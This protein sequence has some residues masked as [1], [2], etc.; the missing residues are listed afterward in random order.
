MSSRFILKR[1]N[2]SSPSV[3]DLAVPEKKRKLKRKVNPDLK[4]PRP[5]VDIRTESVVS[6]PNRRVSVSKRGRLLGGQEVEP[7]EIKSKEARRSKTYCDPSTEEAKQLRHTLAEY[8]TF[9]SRMKRKIRTEREVHNM[10]VS[11]L[12]ETNQMLRDEIGS[13]RNTIAEMSNNW[14]ND[15]G[16]GWVDRLESD[17]S[18]IQTINAQLAQELSDLSETVAYSDSVLRDMRTKLAQSDTELMS[19]ATERDDLVQQLDGMARMSQSRSREEFSPAPLEEFSCCNEG[20][21]GWLFGHGKVAKRRMFV[22]GILLSVGLGYV[23]QSLRPTQARIQGDCD[24][25]VAEYERILR[26]E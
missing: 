13:V 22:F 26:M 21:I 8:E 4:M 14:G 11:D 1:E 12:Q 15:N 20:V 6:S 23:L 18:K 9:L 3:V 24:Y 10:Q 19:M 7:F 16:Q 5:M 17:N 25:D 2:N